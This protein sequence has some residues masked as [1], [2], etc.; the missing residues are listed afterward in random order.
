MKTLLKITTA[1]LML[2]L[3]SLA[4]LVLTLGTETG[5]RWLLTLPQLKQQGLSIAQVHGHLLGRLE[6]SGVQVQTRSLTFNSEQLVLDWSPKALLQSRLHIVELSGHGLSYQDQAAAEPSEPTPLTFPAL[7]V[8]VV[9]EQLALSH[10]EI[11]TGEAP[12]IIDSLQASLALTEQSLTWSPLTISGLNGA[13][14]SSGQLRLTEHL[15]VKATLDWSVTPP[16]QPLWQGR[17]DASGDLLRTLKLALNSTTP[18]AS[19]H[20]LTVDNLASRPIFNLASQWTATHWPLD[21]K[22]LALAPGTLTLTGALDDYQLTLATAWQLPNMPKV[23]ARLTG[24]G[25]LTRFNLTQA[26]LD[27]GDSQII[28]NGSLDWRQDLLYDL[29]LTAHQLR[30]EHWQAPVTGNINVSLNSQGRWNSDGLT[31]QINL[32]NLNGTLNGYAL[33]GQSRIILQQNNLTIEQLALRSGDNTLTAKGQL[34]PEQG[35]LSARLNASE[36][37]QLLPGATGRID[38]VLTVNGRWS[39]PSFEAKFNAKNVRFQDYQL[40][41]LIFDANITANQRGN[42]EVNAQKLSTSQMAL[43]QLA[44]NGHGI[45][46]EHRL[47]IMAKGPILHLDTVIQGGWARQRW[48]GALQ[49][50][51]GN[52][53]N[54]LE[55]RLS[56][57]VELSLSQTEVKPG[58]GCLELNRQPI[59]WQS[60]GAWPKNLQISLNSTDFDLSQL[61]P[62]LPETL[63]LSGTATSELKLDWQT[64]LTHARLNAS[65]RNLTLRFD[66]QDDPLDY[67]VETLTIT[68]DY[69]PQRLTG[70]AT[71]TARENSLS[72]DLNLTQ[73]LDQPLL[74][75]NLNI[76]WRDFTPLEKLI[77]E[78][79]PGTGR[80]N[81]KLLATGQLSQPEFNGQLALALDTLD[82]PATGAHWENITLS[83]STDAQSALLL[84][85]SIDSKPGQLA[86]S[87]ALR[88]GNNDWQGQL[89]LSGQV[90]TILRLPEAEANISPD[91][92]ITLA[93]HQTRITGRVAV[94]RARIALEKLPEQ[95]I[96]P[97]ADETIVGES[98]PEPSQSSPPIDASLDLV[99]ALGEQVSFDGYGLSGKL[100]GELAVTGLA[101]QP[102]THGKIQMQNG[103]Y[104]AFGQELTITQGEFLFNGPAARPWL[105]LQV[106]RKAAFEDITAL[107]RVTGPADAP[108]TSISARPALP[109]SE[110]LAYLITGRSLQRASGEQ[111]QNLAQAALKLGIGHLDWVAAQAGLDELS[112]TEAEQLE[113]T[114]LKLGKYVTPD[115]YVGATLGFFTNSYELLLKQQL[116]KYL[117]LTS[118]IGKS[119]RLEVQYQLDT[120]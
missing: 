29:T 94:P 10:L 110:A 21:E 76:D 38:G 37:G 44:I 75:G 81:G 70:T 46:T 31:G 72:A 11:L 64:Q 6:L 93:D 79:I 101:H 61:K 17:L 92:R 113:Q 71:V 42:L 84:S 5:T 80:L 62:W 105:N 59:C 82:L 78:I 7:P 47:S 90:F 19:Q 118:Q 120:D 102:A 32:A 119:Q 36:L 22:N 45:L 27:A 39:A 3:L 4:A 67:P 24:Q 74:D 43:D 49:Q 111:S 86:F 91:M 33:S 57:P 16:G 65:S 103:K 83:V 89:T 60:S 51:I 13:V 98:R 104:Q 95:A 28:L 50:L 14:N 23:K 56:S 115:L 85:G 108:E 87:G 2:A 18:V 25:D 40:A 66:Y 35:Q 88:P 99:L 68:A 116:T 117:N 53:G 114:A 30:P 96:T 69:R 15:P 77:P 97:S 8:S 100:S 63:A 73:L 41:T 52:W 112:V 109:E 20:D 58:S 1:G 106:E 26:R 9:I 12:I 48:H 55:W 107:L 34:T 54:S